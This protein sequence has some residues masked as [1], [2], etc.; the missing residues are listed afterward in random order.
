MFPVQGSALLFWASL[1]HLTT[2]LRVNDLK[3]GPCSQAAHLPPTPKPSYPGIDHQVGS[4]VHL[5]QIG[6]SLLP[7]PILHLVCLVQVIQCCLCDVHPAKETHVRS[8]S[9]AQAPTW[10]MPA[11][12]PASTPS[13]TL[14][15]LTLSL[16]C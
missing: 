6:V 11:P 15:T 14:I 16:P 2:V 1:Y 5:F 8:N 13:P 7:M 10:G 12:S 3:L 4:D 9:M